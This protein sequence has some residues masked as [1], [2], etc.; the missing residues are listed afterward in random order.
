MR[1]AV[2]DFDAARAHDFNNDLQTYERTSAAETL[3]REFF[4]KPRLFK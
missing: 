1:T 4:K 3:R 2:D